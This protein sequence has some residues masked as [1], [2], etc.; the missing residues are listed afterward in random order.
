MT[1]EVLQLD[2]VDVAGRTLLAHYKLATLALRVLRIKHGGILHCVMCAWIVCKHGAQQAV[3]T[4]DNLYLVTFCAAVC[5][6]QFKQTKDS[7]PQVYMK[8]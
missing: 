3:T 2:A 1:H 4:T 6:Q 8:C 7:V 5:R